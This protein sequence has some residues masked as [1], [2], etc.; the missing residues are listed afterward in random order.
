MVLP[1]FR[2]RQHHKTASL[3]LALSHSDKKSCK[4]MMIF[5]AVG[6]SQFIIAMC[7]VL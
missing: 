4:K 2:I 6:D 5:S 7:N 3:Q 1:N